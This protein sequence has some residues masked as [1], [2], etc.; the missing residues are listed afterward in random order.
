MFFQSGSQDDGELPLTMT[1]DERDKLREQLQR[2]EA[3]IEDLKKRLKASKI[4]NEI[5]DGLVAEMKIK[6]SGALNSR[7]DAIARIDIC[8]GQY[9]EIANLTEKL[10]HLS[11]LMKESE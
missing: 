10:Q 1:H 4:Q 11:G 6:Y 5:K 2:Y 7:E 9:E 3:T 8:K